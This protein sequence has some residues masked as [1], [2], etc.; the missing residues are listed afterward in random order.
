MLYV[1]FCYPQNIYLKGGERMKVLVDDRGAQEKEEEKTQP[2][3]ILK[4][5]ENTRIQVKEGVVSSLR[6]LFHI[7]WQ[8]SFY[9]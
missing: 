3:K 7:L 5:T 8:F 6:L 2:M 1:C 4:Q 9:S